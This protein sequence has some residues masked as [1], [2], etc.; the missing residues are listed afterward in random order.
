MDVVLQN[1]WFIYGCTFL[2]I[3]LPVL[4]WR[5]DTTGA[6]KG[7]DA[8]SWNRLPS[9][10]KTLWGP[11]SVLEFP[12][13]MP[14]SK[15]FSGASEQY[16]RWIL[17]ADLPLT[18]AKVFALR[19]LLALGGAVAGALAFMVPDLKPMWGA[20]IAFGPKYS[21]SQLGG[22]ISLKMSMP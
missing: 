6:I 14:L 19:V 8:A 13:G 17:A 16:S 20:L 1:S 4:M 5:R 22:I 9:V 3:V 15:M 21:G 12:V 10:F 2:A 11:A 7:A 18:P